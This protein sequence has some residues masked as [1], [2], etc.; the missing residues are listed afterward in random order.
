MRV[1]HAAD[2]E[3]VTLMAKPSNVE[4]NGGPGRGRVYISI[5]NA[6]D[7]VKQSEQSGRRS[8]T[9]GN[10]GDRGRTS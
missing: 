2:L 10:P 1:P 3:K 9:R 5:I 7:M 4:L 6:R 8:A